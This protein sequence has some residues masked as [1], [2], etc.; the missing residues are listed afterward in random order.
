MFVWMREKSLDDFRP[1]LKFLETGGVRIPYLAPEDLIFLKE[2]SWR[3]KDKF[4][5]QAM[6]EIIVREGR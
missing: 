6:R 1:R 3:E 4:D 2:G 5:V